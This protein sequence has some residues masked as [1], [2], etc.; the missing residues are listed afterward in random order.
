MTGNLKWKQQLAFYFYRDCW[1]SHLTFNSAY[2]DKYF[3]SKPHTYSSFTFWSPLSQLLTGNLKWHKQK[4]LAFYF[5]RD[6]GWNCLTSNSVYMDTYF[7]SELHTYFSSDPWSPFSQLLTGN[8]KWH[9]QKPLAFYFHRDYGS[10]NLTSKY[11][12]IDQYF[13]W[14][15]HT[16]FSSA[17]WSPLSQL[18]TS[19]LNWHQP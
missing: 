4:P 19:N 10:N 11:I 15:P 13:Q 14:E 2:M 18:L 9:K 6:Y 7:R 8:L 1:S 5:Y 17:F 3:Q 16:Y 12:N